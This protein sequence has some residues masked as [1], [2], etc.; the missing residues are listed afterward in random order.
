MKS[1][2]IIGCGTGRCGTVSLNMVLAA[3]KDISIF[4]EGFGL[5]WEEDRELF[6]SCILRLMQEYD[7]KFIGNVSFAWCSYLSMIFTYIRDPRV[8]VMKREREKVVHSF[9]TRTEFVKIN[10]WTKFD[11]EHWD[12]DRWVRDDALSHMFPRYDLPKREAIG[13]YWDDYYGIAEF[14]V[15]RFP[16]NIRIFQMEDVLNSKEGQLK[17]LEFAGFEDPVLAVDTKYNSSEKTKNSN[18]LE[19]KAA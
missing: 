15:N 16:D 10:N 4:H 18:R 14:W 3:Q 2:L 11:S 8:I 6:F 5:P 17:M 1:N 13:A 9:Y 7:A 19:V 12:D